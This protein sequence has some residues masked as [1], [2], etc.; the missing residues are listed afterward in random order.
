MRLSNNGVSTVDTSN[1]PVFGFGNSSEDRCLSTAHLNLK[2]GGRPGLL[3]AH[4]LD[5]GSAPVLLSVST[6]RSLGAIIDFEASKMVLRAVDAQ[7]LIALEQSKA[8]HLLLPLVGDILDNS[9][10]TLRPA[11]SLNDFVQSEVASRSP[12]E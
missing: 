7:K 12:D 9:T 3:K 8:G 4:A 11:P 10:Q 2:A 5:K 1:Q 6:L